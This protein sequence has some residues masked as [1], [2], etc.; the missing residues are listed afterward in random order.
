MHLKRNFYNYPTYDLNEFLENDRFRKWVIDPTEGEHLFWSE[1]LD[2]Y[3]EKAEIVKEATEILV[4]TQEYMGTNEV[5]EEDLQIGLGIVLEK[6]SSLEKKPSNHS[7]S[8]QRNMLF[9]PYRWAMIAATLVI[10]LVG[11]YLYY[12]SSGLTTYT[13][14]FGEWKTVVLPDGSKVDLNANSELILADDWSEGVTRHVWLKGEAFFQVAKQQSTN[15]KFQVITNDLTIEVLGTEFNVQDRGE[16]TEVYLHEG[17][18]KLDLGIG[19]KD[20]D[21]GDFVSFSANKNK[22]ISHNNKS[23]SDYASWK[24]G[25]LKLKN[26]TILEILREVEEIYG[27]EVM[28]SNKAMLAEKRTIGVPMKNL[29]I[30]IPIL[31]TTLGAEVSKVG[32]KLL[33]K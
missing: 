7:T 23:A 3:P 16:Q 21:P 33:V 4:A 22:V 15:S 13:T 20:L 12:S 11:G 2:A 8:K 5:N 30:V 29:E 14:D 10:G 31:E 19:E 28:I 17:K 26:A 25:V 32:D 27:V 1:F 18:I 9:T 6:A 24:E